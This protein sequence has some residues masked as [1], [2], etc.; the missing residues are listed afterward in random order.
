MAARPPIFLADDFVE[1]VNVGWRIEPGVSDP[2]N[3]LI[4]PKYPWDSGCTFSHGTVMIDPFD[5]KW[6]MWYVSTPY[7]DADNSFDRRLTYAE[8]ED[9]EH[10]V[11][12]MVDVVP[13]RGPLGKTNADFWKESAVPASGKTTAPLCEKTNILLDHSS[14]GSCAFASVFVNADAPADERYE[15]FLFRCPLLGGPRRDGVPYVQGLSPAAKEDVKWL[16]RYTSGDGIHWTAKDGP[17][18]IATSDSCW[19]YKEL[20]AVTGHRYVA[21]HKAELRGEL[22]TGFTARIPPY[23]IACYTPEH[24]DNC[25]VQWRRTSDDGIHWSEKELVLAPDPLDPP[26]TQ[27]HELTVFPYSDRGLI[28]MVAAEHCN[29]QTLTQY[30]AASTDGVNW[31]R[32]SRRRPCVPLAPLGEYGGG[33]V[34]GMRMM[35]EEGDRMHLYYCGLQNEQ[36]TRY[37]TRSGCHPFNGA[38]MR[39]TWQTGR[40]WAAVTSRG[41]ASEGQL[42]TRPQEGLEG[43][44]L[45]VNAATSDEGKVE[46]ELVDANGE[47]IVGY[48]RADCVPLRGD[49]RSA[50][51]RW[52]GG[53]ACPIKSASVRVFFSGSRLYGFEWR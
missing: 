26:D 28:G 38:M 51:M 22:P 34:Y 46:A 13:F 2:A 15:M 9:G 37:G 53:S 24:N 42:L 5:G 36:N 27:F 48:R 31:W 32:P 11:R 1:H 7:A 49:H 41:G 12:P 25:R 43:K 19:I 52:R 6:K 23:E 10:W 14:G 3:P 33:S 44:S 40:F 39:A 29:E 8:S 21:H 50:T 30:F 47:A 4:E 45:V 20:S 35:V 17:I 16:C 18:R